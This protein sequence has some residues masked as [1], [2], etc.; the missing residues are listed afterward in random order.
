MR[1]Y[2]PLKR[3]NSGLET[4]SSAEVAKRALVASHPP[5]IAVKAVKWKRDENGQPVIEFC[6]QNVGHSAATIQYVVS[7]S[8]LHSGRFTLG[9][10][11]KAPHIAQHISLRDN[12]VKRGRPVAGEH[13]C[14]NINPDELPDDPPNP[15]GLFGAI[16]VSSL[17]NMRPA[18]STLMTFWV[19]VGI[20]DETG[21]LDSMMSH[22]QCEPPAHNFESVEAAADHQR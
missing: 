8:G 22:F 21:G 17:A 15:T 12:V 16:P 2:F 3:P 19:L 1:G 10:T 14:E 20:E 11:R 4:A 6:I 13:R 5:T 18:A 9:R 7:A